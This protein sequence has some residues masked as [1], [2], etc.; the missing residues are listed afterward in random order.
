MDPKPRGSSPRKVV[1]A[2]LIGTT[3]EWYDFF[4]FGV[5]AALIFNELFFP[6]F[7]PLVGTLLAFSTYAIGFVARPIGGIVF[8]HYG[9]KIG[10]K[11][12]LVLSLGIMG[13]AT[14]CIGLLPSYATIGVAAPILLVVLRFVQGFAIGGEWGG[15]I[16]M[17]AEHGGAKRRGLFASWPQAGVPIGNLLAVGVVSLL[18]LL[19]S[20]AAFEAWGWRVAFLLSAVLVG[21]GLWVRAT[22][23]ESPEFQAL[24]QRA[25]TVRTPI[26]EVVRT[27]PR[28]VLVAMGA[29]FAENVSYYIFTVFVLTYVTE[30]LGLERS[31]A[32][33]A[34]LIAS[35]VHL[36]AIPAWGA[37]S[38]RVGRRP[39][40][41]FGAAGVGVWGFVFFALLD[42]AS[43]AAITLAIAVGLVLHAAMYGPQAAFFT[44]M[45]GTGVRYSGVSIGYQLAS[46]FAGSLAPIV[47]VALLAE[48]GSALP[49]SFYLA[50]TA[51]ITLVALAFAREARVPDEPP[52]PPRPARF[53]REPELESAA[54]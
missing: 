44:E 50:G 2:S 35:A 30:E 16:L 9:D 54:R 20:A 42:T 38:D 21:V 10:R 22:L 40:Y 41:V 33:N 19:T 34:V 27:H 26:V 17:A 24:E 28:S 25:E 1:V 12:M 32:L 6:D 14:F 8:G 29:R 31:W 3:I 52:V 23:A 5:A 47:A 46:V 11:S 43:F 49:V 53:E 37:L 36:L 39:L 48:Y 51:V 45:F 13:V 18:G 4:L 7:E 15:A